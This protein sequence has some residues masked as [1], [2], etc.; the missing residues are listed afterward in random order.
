MRSF[1]SKFRSNSVH[2]C[3]G[4]E[5]TP[6][7][8]TCQYFSLD[9]GGFLGCFTLERSKPQP[10]SGQITY[11]LFLLL[12]FVPPGLRTN[13]CSTILVPHLGQDTKEEILSNCSSLYFIFF[14]VIPCPQ[15]TVVLKA[16][17]GHIIRISLRASYHQLSSV[18]PSMVA[19]GIH[20]R[21]VNTV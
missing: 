17:P 3:S 7:V 4:N 13:Q 19:V 5:Y 20:Y 8:F 9:M 6:N 11:F 14:Q 21:K 1:E 16:Y 2:H 10:L 18:T 12:K 15:D